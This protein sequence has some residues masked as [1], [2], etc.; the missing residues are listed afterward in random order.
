MTLVCQTAQLAHSD[1]LKLGEMIATQQYVAVGLRP[2]KCTSPFLPVISV[3]NGL[4]GRGLVGL[5]GVDCSTGI[6]GAGVP[7]SV[8]MM[9]AF[10]MD[11]FGDGESGVNEVF[12]V[13]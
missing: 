2:L 4:P 13:E 5:L 9:V 6:F 3:S 10:L 8:T 11:G 7:E 12:G 1:D